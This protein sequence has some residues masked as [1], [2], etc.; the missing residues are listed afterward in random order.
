MRYRWWYGLA[1]PVAAAITLVVWRMVAGEW[2]GAI[3]SGAGGALGALIIAG[4]VLPPLLL[5]LRRERRERHA[6]RMTTLRERNE[7]NRQIAELQDA[8][9]SEEGSARRQQIDDLTETRAYL[10][11]ALA[12]QQ[13]LERAPTGALPAEPSPARVLSEEDLAE[14][15][16]LLHQSRRATDVLD[17]GGWFLRGNALYE[18]MHYEDALAAYDHAIALR[19]DLL[20]ARNNSGT[21]AF[22][23]KRY[24]EALA[25]YDHVLE[26]QADHHHAHY[27]RSAALTRLGRY[28]EALAAAD[29]AADLDPDFPHPHYGRV[30]ALGLLGRSEEAAAAFDGAPNPRPGDAGGHITRGVALAVLHRYEE[31]LRSFQRALDLRRDTAD[32]LLA[33]PQ[34][35][36]LRDHPE[37]GPRLRELIERYRDGDASP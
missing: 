4:P 11:A 33:N 10:T 36:P 23:L 2:P 15:Q 37:Y 3:R 13:V 14:L 24:D 18:A 29:R 35:E 17:A 22:R 5:Q 1:L 6:D 8:G 20:D 12:Q 26:F 27:G 16:L 21:A 28:E 9:P 7:V 34:L 30:V 32:S 31:A 25:A 19:P